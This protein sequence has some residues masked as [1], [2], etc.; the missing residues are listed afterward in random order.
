MSEVPDLFLNQLDG[1]MAQYATHGYVIWD[2]CL[3]EEI[4][5]RYLNILE[6]MNEASAFSEAHIGKGEHKQH[7]SSRRSDRIC[8]LEDEMIQVTFSE[9][10]QRLTA[11]QNYVNRSFYMGLRHIELH[12]AIYGPGRHYE[13]HLDQ[14]QHSD[15]R[16]IT[17]VFYLN[18]DWTFK[19]GGL[20]KLYIEQ[21]DVLDIL[22]SMGRMVLFDSARFEHEVTPSAQK[23]RYSI[24]GWFRRDGFLN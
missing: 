15:S 13:R 23:D 6:G 4:C 18:P 16:V 21:N 22:P 17:T 5:Y 8:W 19:D 7:A 14:H 10:N 2:Q 11:I 20:L 12:A 1:V 3:P 24:T 9:L